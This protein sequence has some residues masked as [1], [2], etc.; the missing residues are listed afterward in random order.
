MLSATLIP[1]VILILLGF[2]LKQKQFVSEAF[3]QGSDRMVYYIF[4][5]ALLIAKVSSMDLSKVPMFDI[6]A[7]IAILLLSLTALLALVQ[8]IRPIPAATFTSVYQGAVRYNTF[9]ALTLVAATWSIPQAMDVAALTVGIKVLLINVLCVSVFALYLNKSVSISH[10]L[11]LV[12]KNPLIIA[13]SLGLVLNTLGIALPTWVL[14]SLDLLGRVA[15]TLGLLSVG[16]GLILS[17]NDWLSY[18]IL[19]SVIFK[20]LLFP[21]A[22]FGLGHWFSLDTISHQVLVLM[23]AMPTAVSA[24]IL[25]GQLGGDQR[26]MAKIITIQT[27]LS[28]LILAVVIAWIA[29]STGLMA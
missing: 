2:V 15:L 8:A 9:I 1:I 14:A 19:L 29:G 7:I 13:C 18:P 26:V 25:A 5:P 4:F 11:L 22:A 27:L 20:L 6:T 10:K 17:F 23:F 3:W 24:Y 16:A 21:L 28:A 12:L